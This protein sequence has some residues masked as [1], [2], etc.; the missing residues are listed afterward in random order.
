[1]ANHSKHDAELT[2]EGAIG[3]KKRGREHL[4]PDSDAGQ[5][6]QKM[7]A[8]KEEGKK[9]GCRTSCT[10]DRTSAS[11]EQKMKQKLKDQG[12]ATTVDAEHGAKAKGKECKCHEME[13][14]LTSIEEKIE[15]L[16]AEVKKLQEDLEDFKREVDMRFDWLNGA[17]TV[18]STATSWLMRRLSEP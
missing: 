3:G 9:N 10:I 7:E 13:D 12:D 8:V 4:P 17:V 2:I 16:K 11:D 5:K 14:Y 15:S 6:K 1:M 18:L